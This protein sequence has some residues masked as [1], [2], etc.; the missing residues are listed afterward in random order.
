MLNPF[1]ALYLMWMH[2][3]ITTLLDL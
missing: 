2:D 3:K 1:N